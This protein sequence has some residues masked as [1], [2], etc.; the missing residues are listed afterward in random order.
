MRQLTLTNK[1]FEVLYDILEDVVNV[2]EGDLITTEDENGN[3][4]LEDITEYEAYKIYQ[5]LI[6][7][8]GGK[9]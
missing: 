7:L 9:S 5:Q 3:E 1:Q 6:H 4:I 8:N 2:I